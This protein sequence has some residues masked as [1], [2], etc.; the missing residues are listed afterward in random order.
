MIKQQKEILHKSFLYLKIS[1]L[2]QFSDL[3]LRLKK[4]ILIIF[5]I[6]EYY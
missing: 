5:N 3:C 2:G 6:I 1:C 4:L